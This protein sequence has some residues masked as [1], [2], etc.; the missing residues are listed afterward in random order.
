MG[1][2]IGIYEICLYFSFKFFSHFEFFGEYKF[3]KK[4][5]IN[6]LEE[7]LIR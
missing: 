7:I 1:E 3:L 5:N 4:K 2:M 6:S